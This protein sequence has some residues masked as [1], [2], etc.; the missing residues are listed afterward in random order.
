MDFTIS[1][2]RALKA[3]V[4]AHSNIKDGSVSSEENGLHSPKLKDYSSKTG[5]VIKTKFLAGVLRLADELDVSSERL[6]TGELEQQIEEGQKEIEKL[7]ESIKTEADKKKIEKWEKYI[8]SL[9]HWKRL[10]LISEVK[11]NQ[12]RDTIELCVDDEYIERCLDDGQTEKSIARDL[13]DIYLEINKKLQEAIQEAF[14]ERRVRKYIPVK[15]VKIVTDNV[16]LDTAIKKFLSVRSLNDESKETKQTFNQEEKGKDLPRLIDEELEKE[17]FDEVNKRNLIKFGHYLLNENYCARDWID[18]KEVVETKKILNKLV[19]AIV[20]DIN[21]KEHRNYIIVGVDLVGAL[22]AS[23]VAFSLQKPLTYIVP[24]KDEDNNTDQEIDLNLDE[25]VDVILVTDAI[26]TYNTINKAISK[27]S[28][29]NKI[30]SIYTIFFRQ[31]DKV[32]CDNTNVEKTLSMNN[33]FGIELFEKQKC[34]Y[35]KNKCIAQNQKLNSEGEN[36]ENN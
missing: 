5:G 32:K 30:D 35:N 1:E 24:E 20:K 21:S 11:R 19:E 16:S 22:L 25:N 18:T 29:E 9:K 3:I 17:I 12:N 36:N 13:I 33:L 8:D 27:Y 34:I 15:Q 28:L 10:H 26:V 2:I 4:L 31:S 23:R 7:K 6:G 14:S